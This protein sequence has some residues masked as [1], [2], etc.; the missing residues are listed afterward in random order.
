MQKMDKKQYPDALDVL[1]KDAADRAADNAAAAREERIKNRPPVIC[2]GMDGNSHVLYSPRNRKTHKLSTDKFTQPH[3]LLLDNKE[4]WIRWLFPER[5]AAGES[6]NR[7]E[8]EE[9]AQNRIFA[10]S[11]NKAFNPMSIRA[12]GIWKNGLGWIYNAGAACW[13]IDTDGNLELVDN[14]LG[15]HVYSAGVALPAPADIALTDAEGANLVEMLTSR[16]WS[17]RG[18]GELVTGWIVSA[19]M[20][21]TLPMSPHVWITAP[22]GTGK[23]KLMD[24]ITAILQSFAIVNEGVPTEAA[25]RQRLQGDALP[26]INDEMEAG[27]NKIASLNI[28][29]VLDLMR[30]ASYGKAPMSKGGADGSARLY[31]MKCGFSFFSVVDSISRDSDLSRCLRLRLTRRKDAREIWRH[32]EVGR[33]LTEQADFP[34]RFVTR[35]LRLLPVITRNVTTLTNHLRALDGVDARKG[36]LFSVLMA[37]RYAL[38]SSEPLTPEQMEHAADMLRAYD[39]QDEKESDS[40]RCLSVLL[41]HQIDVYNAGRMSAGEAIRLMPTMCDGETKDNYRRALQLIGLRWREDLKA[42]QV[43]PRPDLMKRIYNG[44][45]WNNGKIAAVLAEGADR[46][47][48]RDGANLAGIWYQ[49]AK[50]GGMTPVRCVMIPSDLILNSEI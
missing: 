28:N 44:T 12:R 9:A 17:F 1:E 5:A 38:T 21:G 48:G 31:P 19:L 29:K 2:L 3:L 24:D 26:W 46:S 11:A 4:S 43:N 16:P 50:V 45:Q 6:V 14:V 22:Q 39:D 18:E 13:F 42:L 36:E 37:C 33:S 49:Q 32:Q 8:L 10:E 25:V 41:N 15:G 20:A 34:S 27:D 40:A 47:K 23:T 7:W 30:S 35:I